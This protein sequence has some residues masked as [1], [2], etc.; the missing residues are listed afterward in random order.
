[1][2]DHFIPVWLRG[3][4]RRRLERGRTRLESGQRASFLRHR[5]DNG[6]GTEVIGLR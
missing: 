5:V 3:R 4:E 1:M 2:V 6:A